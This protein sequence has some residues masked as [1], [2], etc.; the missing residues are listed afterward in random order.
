MG[1][2]AGRAPGPRCRQRASQALRETGSGRHIGRVGLPEQAGHQAQ[3]VLVSRHLAKPGAAATC[4]SP[5]CLSPSAAGDAAASQDAPRAQT[6]A[7]PDHRYPR[8]HGPVQMPGVP[9]PPQDW[10][11]RA[12]G[13]AVAGW[14]LRGWLG[15]YWHGSWFADQ[16]TVIGRVKIGPTE[17]KFEKLK[18]WYRP[19]TAHPRMRLGVPHGLSWAKSCLTD[20]TALLTHC[21][22]A[23]H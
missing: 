9:L 15:R 12:A 20:P 10:Q 17:K 2:G 1:G 5:I 23:R 22:K 13:G 7:S 8:L 6:R 4:T 3:A 14:P 11:G 19:P 16:S 21:L 18:F